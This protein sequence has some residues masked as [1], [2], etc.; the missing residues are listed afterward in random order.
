MKNYYGAS[1]HGDY[2]SLTFGQGRFQ[3]CIPGTC[4]VKTGIDADER[5]KELERQRKERGIY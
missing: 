1:I 4:I 2:S 5:E 3:N